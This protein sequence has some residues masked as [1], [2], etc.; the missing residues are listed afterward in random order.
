MGGFY[1]HDTDYGEQCADTDG[2][3]LKM[4]VLAD[5]AARRLDSQARCWH[6]FDGGVCVRCGAQRVTDASRSSQANTILTERL[7]ATEAKLAAAMI[8]MGALQSRVVTAEQATRDIM[9]ETQRLSD[10]CISQAAELAQRPQLPAPEVTEPR[11]N[12]FAYGW[13]TNWRMR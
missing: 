13:A 11:G 4:V 12:P 1:M 5:K 7:L 3:A 6:A 2:L 9:V 10:L 8:D